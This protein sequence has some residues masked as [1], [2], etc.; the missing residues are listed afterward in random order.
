MK[1]TYTTWSSKIFEGF[2]ESNLF[3]S[4]TE[5]NLSEGLESPHEIKD[6]A[7][8]CKSVSEKVVSLLD[9]MDDSSPV[10][11][12]KLDYISSPQYYNYSSDKLVIQLDLDLVKLKVYC[13]KLN[14]ESFGKYLKDNFTSRDGFISFVPNNIKDF[15]LELEYTPEPSTEYTLE[16]KKLI[17]VMIEFYLISETDMDS[18]HQELYEY[19][20][21]K[22][23]E[24]AEP[25]EST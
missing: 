15:V 25:V 1:Y 17:D 24:Y 14:S 8:F 18:Y 12:L 5:Y 4:D 9:P 13:L 19:A 3:N 2:Y 6:F 21:E 11:N 16:S 22:A 7:G 23:Y 20:W 10:Q